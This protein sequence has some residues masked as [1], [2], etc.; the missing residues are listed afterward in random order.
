MSNLSDTTF[1][2]SS[3]FVTLLFQFHGSTNR[4]FSAHSLMCGSVA[5]FFPTLIR[6]STKMCQL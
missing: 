4:I 2:D 6:M 1:K 5:Q 3:V